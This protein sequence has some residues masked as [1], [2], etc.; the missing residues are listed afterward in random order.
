MQAHEADDVQVADVE[1]Q[2]VASDETDGLVPLPV[3]RIHLEEEEEEDVEQ[4]THKKSQIPKYN[5]QEDNE[6]AFEPENDEEEEPAPSKK[7]RRG[8]AG[9]RAASS[10]PT[11]PPSTQNTKKQL[12]VSTAGINP[13]DHVNACSSSSA[14]L[15]VPTETQIIV[16]RLLSNT[17]AALPQD[18]EDLPL[19][20]A[21]RVLAPSGRLPSLSSEVLSHFEMAR[22][23]PSSRFEAILDDILQV[24]KDDPFAK[25]VIFSQ[26]IDSL[27]AMQAMFQQQNHYMR[28]S[29]FY[30]NG[31]QLTTLESQK[32]EKQNAFNPVIVDLSST[33]GQRTIHDALNKF[34]NDPYCD[35]CMLTTGASAAGLTLTV[36]RV[37]YML[38]PS[39]NAAE[40][41]QALSR[42]HRIGQKHSV[43]CVIFY[44]KDTMEERILALRKKQ[45]TLTA[46]LSDL[47]YTDAIESDDEDAAA[48]SEGALTALRKR[49]K[50]EAARRKQSAKLNASSKGY[51]FYTAAQ[52]EILCGLTEERMEQKQIIEHRRKDSE[53]THGLGVRRKFGAISVI[54]LTA[55]ETARASSSSFQAEGGDVDY[56]YSVGGNLLPAAAGAPEPIPREYARSRRAPARFDSQRPYGVPPRGD[57]PQRSFV[58]VH[59]S[60]DEGEEDMRANLDEQD[61]NS[62]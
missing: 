61:E 41:A 57:N 18:Y 62:S 48:E 46:I 51:V 9:K 22:Y 50:R 5:D 27:R 10:K 26:H 32:A 43:R 45:K 15:A 37:C 4:M 49:Q 2:H 58:S 59:S 35:V 1:G 3:R 53:Q 56:M 11:R 60:S 16:P 31:N 36:A 20:P 54:N 17:S 40:E 44:A 23:T 14:V 52:M 38:E 12:S 6:E 34:N 47:T 39:Q 8:S 55:A 28:T 24:R 7:K 30:A 19:L 21:H 33:G 13:G 25:F 42:I 29:E